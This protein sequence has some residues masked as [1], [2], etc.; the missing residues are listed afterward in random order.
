MKAELAAQTARAEE[1][2]SAVSSLTAELARLSPFEKEVREKNL[3]IGKLRHEAVTLNDHLTKALRL[4][5]KGK[6]EDN[7]DRRMVSNHFIKFLALDRTDPKKFQILQLIAAL[8][9]WDED[10]REQAGLARPGGTSGLAAPTPAFSLLRK[11]SNSNM[12]G[13]TRTES[14]SSSRGPLSPDSQSASRESLSDLLKDMLEQEA[15]SKAGP[16][17]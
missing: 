5:K 8:L 7:V 2:S 3:L 10:E 4:L 14:F 16:E 12:G 11:K 6:P 17:S 13:M 9:K 15:K 1:A